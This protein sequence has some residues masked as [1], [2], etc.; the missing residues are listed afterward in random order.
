VAV[1][2]N[3]SKSIIQ[4]KV[5]NLAHLPK[6]T[7][8]Q[9]STPIEQLAHLSKHLGGPEIYVKRDDLLGLSAGGN[10]TRKLEYLLADALKQGATTLITCGAI[11]SNHC[12][13]TLSA[14]VKEGLKCRFILEERVA[15]SYKCNGNGN[16][17]LYGL[18]G[19]EKVKVVD[20]GSNMQEQMQ[21]LA[22]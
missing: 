3:H 13:L 14:A 9:G 22:D 1:S 5:M 10:K 15:G 18:L 17:L 19:V 4:K 20:G 2:L 12:R 7:Y 21:E 11:Q 6:R 8:T 16:D